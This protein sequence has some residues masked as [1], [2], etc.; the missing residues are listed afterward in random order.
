M[1]SRQ[2]ALRVAWAAARSAFWIEARQ[3]SVT[4]GKRRKK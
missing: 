3:R 2:V 4:E 1:R